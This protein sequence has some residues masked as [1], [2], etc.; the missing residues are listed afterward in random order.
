M[1]PIENYWMYTPVSIITKK[2]VVE[3]TCTEIS[4]II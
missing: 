4:L 1:E 3:R 2:F